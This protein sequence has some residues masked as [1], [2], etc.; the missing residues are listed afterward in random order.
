MNKGS[1]LDIV[2]S[3]QDTV[4]QMKIDDLEECPESAFEIFQCYCC[5]QEK[6]KAGSMIYG[7]YLLCNDCVLLAETSFALGRISNI[8][9]LINSMEDKRLKAECDLLS[10][11]QKN[12]NNEDQ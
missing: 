11:E 12:P 2:K 4:E 10:E 6:E 1:A 5:G 8:E 3:L 9:E 7:D